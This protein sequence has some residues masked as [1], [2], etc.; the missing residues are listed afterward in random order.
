MNETQL[1]VLSYLLG[2][3]PTGYWIGRFVFGINLLETGSKNTGATNA[4]RCL[5]QK[6]GI[7]VLVLDM[8]KGCLPVLLAQNYFQDPFLP[9]LAALFAIIG[10]TLSPFLKFRGGKGVATSAGAFLAL[11]PKALLSSFACF[12][13][14]VF[15]T[16]YISL[17]SIIACLTLPAF[18]FW[19]YPDKPWLWQVSLPLGLFIVFKHRAN[20]SRLWKGEEN[21]FRWRRDV[22]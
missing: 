9:A 17:G 10:H 21:K 5:G 8:S 19:F 11:A 3:I 12:F 22:S 18:N 4:F 2:S 14:T 6:T 7:L 13:V 16:A 1:F 15:T 20:L